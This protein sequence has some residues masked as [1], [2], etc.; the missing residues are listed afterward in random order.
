MYLYEKQQEIM[1]IS[2]NWS[3]LSVFD[4]FDS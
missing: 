4:S 2:K 1:E 3:I